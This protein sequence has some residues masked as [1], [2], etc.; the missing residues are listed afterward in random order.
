MKSENTK[1]YIALSIPVAMLI[2]VAAFVYFPGIG[3]H[4]TY[5]FLYATGTY[6]STEGYF[7]QNGKLMSGQGDPLPDA[8]SNPAADH[9]ISGAVPSLAHF[10]E[11]NV[12]TNSATLLSLEQ[13]QALELDN[14]IKSP[15]G[16]IVEEGNGVG[17][18]WFGNGEGDDSNIWYIKGYNRSN[19]LNLQLDT[20]SFQGNNF[21]FLGWVQ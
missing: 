5:N 7:V 13:A 20:V 3:K 16:Y 17:N 19:A 2:I 21:Q 8:N 9:I 6:Q 1:L 12:T 14:S 15:D 18:S 11:Y 10:Y 4:P